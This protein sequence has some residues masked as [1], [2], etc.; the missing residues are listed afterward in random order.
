[1]KRLL[2]ALFIAFISWPVIAQTNVADTFDQANEAYNNAKYDLAAKLYRSILKEDLSSAE[3]HYNLANAELKQNNI[4]EAILH[5]EKALQFKPNATQIKENLAYAN[6]LT[7]DEIQAVPK[8][9]TQQLIEN[10]NYLLS[11]DGWAYLVV[12]LCLAMLLCL[13]V[14][15]WSKSTVF[16][17][18]F[19]GL[20]LACFVLAAI[21]FTQAYRL[22][23]LNTTT[24]YAVILSQEIPAFE[25]PNARASELFQ[26]HEGTKVKLLSVFNDYQ[27]VMLADGTRVWIKQSTFQQI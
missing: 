14:Y 9:E 24:T 4:G 19:F 23:N 11:V 7:I 27:E 25:E 12:A 3:L 8:S 18:V 20:A 16:K 15:G 10:F 6:T 17:R 1:M 13:L 26:L 21:S 5:Y 2:L 22:H